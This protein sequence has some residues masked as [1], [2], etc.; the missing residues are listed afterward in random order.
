MIRIILLVITLGFAFSADTD[1]H[2]AKEEPR[3]DRLNLFQY[4]KLVKDMIY[5]I[6]RLNSELKYVKDEKTAKRTV[7]NIKRLLGQLTALTEKMQKL[8]PP[9]PKVQK[10]LSEKYDSKMKAS[11]E[12]FSGLI[13][14]LQGKEY[15]SEILF[16]ISPLEN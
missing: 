9:S 6:N 14:G 7:A 3:K 4:E 8:P 10:E 2:L 1:T 15:A 12:E 5:K 16:L 11:V 13:V